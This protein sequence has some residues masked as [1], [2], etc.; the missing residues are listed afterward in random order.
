M[1]KFIKRS[2]LRSLKKGSLAVAANNIPVISTAH[3]AGRVVTKAPASDNKKAHPTRTPGCDVCIIE[4]PETNG[5]VIC[6]K[7][8]SPDFAY[9]E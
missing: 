3:A 6:C 8:I 2:L 1:K 5:S 9:G 4:L 7:K